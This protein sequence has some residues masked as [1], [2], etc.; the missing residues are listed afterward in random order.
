MPQ[1]FTFLFHTL[2]LILAWVYFVVAILCV[3]LHIKHLKNKKKFSLGRWLFLILSIGY[4]LFF[5][6]SR[7]FFPLLWENVFGI[8]GIVAII[9]S[10]A[11]TRYEDKRSGQRWW[12]W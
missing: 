1:L 10:F 11:W 5:L 2:P 12:N 4:A 8:L 9:V 3:A 6:I 7:V